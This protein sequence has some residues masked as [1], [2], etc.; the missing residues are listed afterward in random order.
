MEIIHK[1]SMIAYSCEYGGPTQN[2]Q[3]SNK[4][5]VTFTVRQAGEYSIA[6]LLAGDH[7][8][9]SPFKKVFLPGW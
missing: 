2:R 6:V 4:M 7:V 3:D 5:K 9:G 8:K 1:G